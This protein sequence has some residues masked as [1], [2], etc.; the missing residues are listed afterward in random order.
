MRHNLMV[1]VIRAV[2]QAADQGQSGSGK[3]VESFREPSCC[4]APEP[5]ALLQGDAGGFAAM[6]FMLMTEKQ[7]LY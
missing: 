5:E 3:C 1:P 6:R 7:H 2:S 4:V